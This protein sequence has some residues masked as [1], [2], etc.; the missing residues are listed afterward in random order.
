MIFKVFS[1]LNNSKPRGTF[2]LLRAQI[3]SGKTEEQHAAHCSWAVT[4][5]VELMRQLGGW[6]KKVQLPP[7]YLL[8]FHIC[9]STSLL[10]L[11]TPGSRKGKG[12]LSN[13]KAPSS[14]W[15]DSIYHGYSTASP[16]GS[17]LAVLG[18]SV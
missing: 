4:I 9:I 2:S 14:S 7:Q 15:P 1:N 11:G 12:G 6:F 13:A 8:H 3:I 16:K 5:P 10:K 18:D 17:E